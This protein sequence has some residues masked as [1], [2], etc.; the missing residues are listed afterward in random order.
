MIGPSAAWLPENHVAVLGFLAVLV[1]A[2]AWAAY[3]GLALGKWI[4]NLSGVADAG[5]VRAA[6]CDAVLGDGAW[7][8]DPLCAAGDAPAACG[9]GVAGA[10]GGR[11]SGRCAVLNTLRSWRGETK[12]PG[13]AIGQSVVIA[14]PIICAMFIFGT[15]AVVAFHSCI[16]AWRSTIRRRSAGRCGWRWARAGRWARWREWRSC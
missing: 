4:F 13:R 12:A 15:G 10:D 1:L 9:P 14:S 8:A 2:L 6:D 3:R 5:G 7:R 11:C 16:R